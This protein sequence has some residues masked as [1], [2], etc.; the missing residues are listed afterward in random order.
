MKKLLFRFLPAI[1]IICTLVQPLFVSAAEPTGSITLEYSHNGTGFADLDIRIFRVG[2][3]ASDG[4][5]R[6]VKPFDGFPVKINGITSQKEWKDAAVTLSAYAVA[7]QVSPDAKASTD[8]AGKVTF[9]ELKTGVYL[10]GGLSTSDDTHVYEFEDFFLILPTPKSDGTLD[11][12]ISAKPKYS[13]EEKP[14]D[15][16]YTS[17]QVVKLW[18]DAGNRNARPVSVTVAILKDG[19]V[20]ETVKL[21]SANNWTYSWSARKDSGT[22]SVVEKDVP[23]T[24]KVA[25]SS[26][27]TVF[28]ITNTDTTTPTPPPTGD[29]TSLWLYILLICL[30]GF[31]LLILGM[32]SMRRG[33][34]EKNR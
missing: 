4:N 30:S 7:N 10:V 27:G 23:N 18:K 12:N 32:S 28:Q 13:S 26:S 15:P 20:Q 5:Y 34:R 1:L 31:G 21:N 22:W 25:I 24:Y 29:T 14:A 16:E 11:Y 19:V 9:Q 6:L 3:Y 17:Y 33:S 2:E 8:K